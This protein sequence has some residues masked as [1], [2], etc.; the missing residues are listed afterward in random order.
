MGAYFRGG[1][2]FLDSLPYFR[3]DATFKTLYR[4]IRIYLKNLPLINRHRD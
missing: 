2:F 3:G 4:M 1:T